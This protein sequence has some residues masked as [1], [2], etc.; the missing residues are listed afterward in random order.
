[1]QM[2]RRKRESGVNPELSRSGEW[3]RHHPSGMRGIARLQVAQA[4]APLDDKHW[5]WA[6]EAVVE[7]DA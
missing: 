5:V 4:T 7:E 3:E 2:G 1:M 6:W